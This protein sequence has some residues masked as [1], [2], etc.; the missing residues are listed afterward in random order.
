LQIFGGHS[1]GSSSVCI[2]AG[3]VLLAFGGVG[4]HA[5]PCSHGA[6]LFVMYLAL[7]LDVCKQT[8]R[9]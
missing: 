3:Y 8:N 6:S 5:L 1:F 2:F 9:V 7:V 4:F